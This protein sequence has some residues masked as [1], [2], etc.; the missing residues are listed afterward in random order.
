MVIRVKDFVL[1]VAKQNNRFVLTEDMIFLKRLVC[2]GDRR[3][4]QRTA[5]FGR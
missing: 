1:R 4:D 2:D 3:A 5:K